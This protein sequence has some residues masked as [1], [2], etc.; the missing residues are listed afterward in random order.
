MGC[1]CVMALG[2]LRLEQKS[3]QVLR[4]LNEQV[5]EYL[6]LHPNAKNQISGKNAESHANLC[7]F[8]VLYFLLFVS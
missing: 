3:Q 7:D 5:N 1:V 8:F 2:K 4:L 6:F